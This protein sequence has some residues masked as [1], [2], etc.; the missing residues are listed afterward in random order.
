[1]LCFPQCS[2]GKLTIR[3]PRL[4]RFIGAKVAVRPFRAYFDERRGGI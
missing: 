3:R 1:M 4:S 2:F